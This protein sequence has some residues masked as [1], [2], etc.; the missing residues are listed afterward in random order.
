VRFSPKGDLLAFADHVETGDDGRVVVIDREGNVKASSGFFITVQ[1]VSW[2]RDGKEV[3]FTASREGAARAIFAMDLSGKER[4]VL[5]VPGTLTVQDITRA[6]RV[7]L[8][9]DNAQFGI[10]GLRAGETNERNLSWFDWSLPSDVSPDGKD[11][12]FFESGEGVG[13]NYSIFMRGMDGSAAVRLGSGAFPALSPDGK[14]VVA[15]DNSSPRQLELLPTGTGQMRQL[16]HDALEHLRV[17]WVPNGKAIVFTASEP[18]HPAR[19]YWMNLVDGK[20]R[21]ITPEGTEGGLVSPDGKYLLARDPDRKRW[22]YPL[23][24][25]DPQPLSATLKEGETPIDWES[26]GQSLLV[27]ERGF[28]LKVSRVFLNSTR[29]ED[30]RSFAPSDAG[31]IATLGGVR[32]S[33][34]RKSY[35][36]DYFRILSDLYVVDGLK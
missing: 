35:V 32:F 12:L 31:G 13:S 2:S 25:G 10:L 15:L 30:V 28:P 3:W 11:L 36:Y 21:A 14:W 34:D 4:V 17:D 22:L 1:G 6:G 9:I 20:T 26:D 16:T 5:R 29:R 33:A 24:G 19:T 27:G 8:T 23:E 7:L 18:N